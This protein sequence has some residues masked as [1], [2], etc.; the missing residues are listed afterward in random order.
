M[1]T[2]ILLLVFSATV[3]RGALFPQARVTSADFIPGAELALDSSAG[4]VA[5]KVSAE[6]A[7]AVVAKEINFVPAEPLDEWE[8]L[9][10]GQLVEL[11]D[12]RSLSVE[13]AILKFQYFFREFLSVLPMVVFSVGFLGLVYLSSSHASDDVILYFF[14]FFVCLLCCALFGSS[15]RAV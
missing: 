9:E 10:E 5:I 13:I 6:G 3:L 15:W 12:E 11:R 14:V 4:N 2:N 8:S 7:A 1:L